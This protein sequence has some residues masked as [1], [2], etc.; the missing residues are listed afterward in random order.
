MKHIWKLM[1]MGAMLLTLSACSTNR[2]LMPMQQTIGTMPIYASQQQ[3]FADAANKA[4][5]GM[6]FPELKGR[7]VYMEVVGCLP[8]S[9]LYDY[10]VDTTASKIAQSGGMVMPV[11]YE[12]MP[13]YSKNNQVEFIPTKTIIPD[14]DYRVVV[15]LETSGA[16]VIDKSKYVFGFI[17]WSAEEFYEGNISLRVTAYPRKD[18]LKAVIKRGTGV[19]KRLVKGGERSDEHFIPAPTVNYGPSRR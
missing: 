13:V 19:V 11:E 8:E 9:K 15:A 2:R 7:T 16:D 18:G 3:L 4:V 5:K 10:V 12:N 6:T 1:T 17:L 14:T